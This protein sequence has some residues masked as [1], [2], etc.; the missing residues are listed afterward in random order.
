M[1]E[2]AGSARSVNLREAA[3]TLAGAHAR[4]GPGCAYSPCRRRAAATRRRR[5]AGRRRRAHRGRARAAGRA[6]GELPLPL[7]LVCARAAAIAR[8]KAIDHGRRQARWPLALGDDLPEPRA[9]GVR[10]DR[11][12]TASTRSPRRPTGGACA[13]TSPPPWDGSTRPSGR[14]GAHAEGGAARRRRA[15]SLHLLPRRSRMPRRALRSD[16]RGRL[17]GIGALGGVVQRCTREVFQHL[18]AVHGAAAAA[19]AAVA[20]TAAVVLG[21]HDEAPTAWR[22]VAAVQASGGRVAPGRRRR[23]SRGPAPRPLRRRVSTVP[24]AGRPAAR[25]PR[26]GRRR[27]ARRPVLLRP[28]LLRLLRDESPMR[29]T[30]MLALLLL[31]LCAPA[32]ALA[33]TF[34]VPWD[35]GT[36]MARRAGRPRPT[37]GCD[38]RLRGRRH[39]LPERRA[40][41]PPIQRLPLPLRRAR[42]RADP[43]RR[44]DLLLLQ[45]ERGDGALRLFVLR[46]AGRHAPPLQRPARST[47]AVATNGANWVELG[48]YNEGDCRLRSRRPAPTTSSFV[49]RLV[50]LS[51]PTAPGLAAAGPPACRPA[52]RQL[53]WA[54]CRPRER[55]AAVAYAVD[56]G[57][58]VALRG[59]ACSWLCGTAASGDAA[60]D[61]GGLADGPHS[62]DRLRAVVRGRR[63]E[64]RTDPFT[65]DRTLPRSRDPRRSDPSHPSPAGGVTRRSRSALSSATAAD[66]VSSTVR[67]YGPSGALVSR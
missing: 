12:P 56:G 35:A 46:A 21:V 17:T 11:W 22:A 58:R 40:R 53:Q 59:Q 54:A 10:R 49:E 48:L 19:T 24:A 15:P 65:V 64:R 50:T 39:G 14:H 18:E 60:I 33:G 1:E 6:R 16:L 5:G 44:H 9:A 4:P 52:L 63:C 37:R 20:V 8:N 66:V 23:R 41:S 28:D 51:D 3:C 42:R 31:A 13:P 67:V 2:G 27:G 30:A 25:A 32:P 29:P 38:L 7:E 47:N 57:A 36:P 43:L 55:G 62:I 45:G 34:V 26:R 61:L